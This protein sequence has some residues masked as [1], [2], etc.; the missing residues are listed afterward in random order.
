ME[1]KTYEQRLSDLATEMAKAN[2]STWNEL[3]AIIQGMHI[4]QWKACAAIAL[5]HMA[6]AYENGYN[7]AYNYGEHCS[8]GHCNYNIQSL[9]LVPQNESNKAD[10]R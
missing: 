7:L 4:N 5:K 6:E 1:S 10:I 9:G 8:Q 3:P 2:I